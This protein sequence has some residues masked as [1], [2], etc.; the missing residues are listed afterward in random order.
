[1]LACSN[2]SLAP[3]DANKM[4]GFAVVPLTVTE[5]PTTSAEELR[6]L[7]MHDE[8]AFTN[9]EFGFFKDN[10]SQISEHLRQFDLVFPK[11]IQ[12]GL[13]EGGGADKVTDDSIGM[14]V[15]NGQT[16]EEEWLLAGKDGWGRTGPDHCGPRA[17][18]AI[19]DA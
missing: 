9:R 12:R 6:R 14:L 19:Y 1:M 10:P 3:K 11:A 13:S 18:L 16:W 7:F 5:L 2:F 17:R 8:T 4:S 15:W